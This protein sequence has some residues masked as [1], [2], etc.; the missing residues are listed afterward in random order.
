MAGPVFISTVIVKNFSYRQIT[1][2]L[3]VSIP[4]EQQML[5]YQDVT[6]EDTGELEILGELVIIG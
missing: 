5:S 2:D 3:L 6:I 1:P 4:V